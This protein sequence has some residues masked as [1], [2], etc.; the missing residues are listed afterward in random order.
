ML[1]KDGIIK[2]NKEDIYIEDFSMKKERQHISCIRTTYDI[3][4]DNLNKVSID[5]FEFSVISRLNGSI[6]FE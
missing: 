2:K 6:T 3:D 1:C 4:S 5:L